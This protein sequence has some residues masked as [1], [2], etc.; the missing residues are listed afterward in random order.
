MFYYDCPLTNS[1]PVVPAP[2]VHP[3]SDEFDGRL[4]PEHFEGRHVEVVD[5]ED[6]KLAEGRT[7]HALASVNIRH[8]VLVQA[9]H[10]IIGCGGA[11][12]DRC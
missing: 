10:N 5:E 11:Y 12:M 6:N 2:E 4:C 8:H 3:L 9:L 1:L 7:E